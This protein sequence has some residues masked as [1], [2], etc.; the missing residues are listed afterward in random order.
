MLERKRV[1]VERD[2]TLRPDGMKLRIYEHRKTGEMFTI[3]DPDLRLDEV[4]AV[5]EEVN[6]LLGVPSRAGG[7]AASAPAEAMADP[8]PLDPE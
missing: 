1:L 7:S 6:Q 2:V 4:A 3:P 5:Q 8:P